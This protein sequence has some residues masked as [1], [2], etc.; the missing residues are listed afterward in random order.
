MRESLRIPI[1]EPYNGELV[2]DLCLQHFGGFFCQTAG[3]SVILSDIISQKVKHVGVRCECCNF[4]ES[5]GEIDTGHSLSPEP[6]LIVRKWAM[7]PN[8]NALEES[9]DRWD[10]I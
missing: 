6:Y 3:M 2:Q 7:L 10:Q 5:V 1:S 9:D 4:C 8:K